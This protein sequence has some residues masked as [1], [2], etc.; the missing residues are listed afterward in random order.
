M[1]R[2]HACVRESTSVRCLRGGE[3]TH[4]KRS[5]QRQRPM[6]STSVRW[7]WRLRRASRS[8]SSNGSASAGSATSVRPSGPLRHHA[9]QVSL[10][11]LSQ[12]SAR[13]GVLCAPPGISDSTTYATCSGAIRPQ[14]QPSHAQEIP[15]HHRFRTPCEFVPPRNVSRNARSYE[16]PC[17]R[18]RATM[19]G[20]PKHQQACRLQAKFICSRVVAK[21]PGEVPQR[22]VAAHMLRV[23]I[24][25]SHS[26][27]SDRRRRPEPML[28]RP[29]ERFCNRERNRH[30]SRVA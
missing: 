21:P 8:V 16:S 4:G 30:C 15:L 24:R 28:S 2:V 25:S 11:A 29:R 18:N 23:D 17:V 6:N 9:R 12:R 1:R 10:R 7:R 22:R 20:T 27:Q 3:K 26:A 13:S 5:R 14:P 19:R